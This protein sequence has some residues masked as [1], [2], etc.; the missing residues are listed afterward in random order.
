MKL[1]NKYSLGIY[2][3][4]RKEM[5][6]TWSKWRT[7]RA[8]VSPLYSRNDSFLGRVG[9]LRVARSPTGEILQ[10]RHGSMANTVH[11]SSRNCQ[12]KV[13]SRSQLLE[14][15]AGSS[16]K[17]DLDESSHPSSTWHGHPLLPSSDIS[18]FLFGGLVPP[19]CLGA[20]DFPEA[21]LLL[22]LSSYIVFT[23]CTSLSKNSCLWFDHIPCLCVVWSVF[24]RLS[25]EVSCGFM[26]KISSQNTSK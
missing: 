12:M 23:A 24:T 14:H 10:E 6:W 13:A 21:Q 20:L 18:S 3:C 17:G 11:S 1:V 22:S 25:A 7:W 4:E 15:A 19:G 8:W 2:T 26:I 5:E 9:S 16:L